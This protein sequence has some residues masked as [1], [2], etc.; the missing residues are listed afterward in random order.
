ML[1]GNKWVNH[2]ANERMSARI[3]SEIKEDIPSSKLN[4]FTSA[5]LMMVNVKELLRGSANLQQEILVFIVYFIN[6]ASKRQSD[7]LAILLLS[8]LKDII[9]PEVYKKII[10]SLKKFKETHIRDVVV[11]DLIIKVERS[12][13]QDI[14]EE[15]KLKAVKRKAVQ[16][17]SESEEVEGRKSKRNVN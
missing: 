17:R 13:K 6:I 7:Q 1:Q 3:S 11:E 2:L 9:N 12:L 4:N 10:S 15:G 5:S 8:E 14:E 16:R